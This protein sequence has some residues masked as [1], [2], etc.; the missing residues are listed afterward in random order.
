MIGAPKTDREDTASSDKTT[1]ASCL[2]RQQSGTMKM[3]LII[4]LPTL[5]TRTNIKDARAQAV[6]GRDTEACVCWVHGLIGKHF[7]GRNEAIA[8]D[9]LH[10]HIL[11]IL[12]IQ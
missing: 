8:R 12:S 1:F 7:A 4:E 6:P 10:C 3:K 9:P 11:L 5:F 2:K